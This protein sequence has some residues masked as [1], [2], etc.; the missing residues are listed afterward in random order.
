M[1]LVDALRVLPQIPMEIYN[2]FG[3]VVTEETRQGGFRLKSSNKKYENLEI[4]YYIKRDKSFVRV[5]VNW[6]TKE[7]ETKELVR[8]FKGMLEF[9]ELNNPNENT[10]GSWVYSYQSLY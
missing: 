8:F 1:E 5:K 2:I 9:I 6:Y 4:K 3:F 7:L 10:L